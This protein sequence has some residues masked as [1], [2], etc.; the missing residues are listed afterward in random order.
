MDSIE[1]EGLTFQ[2]GVFG[3]EIEA[4]RMGSGEKVAL[5][6]HNGSGKTT[7]LEC[8]VGLQKPTGRLEVLGR[9]PRYES[10]ALYPE[11]SY[12]MQNPDD[13]LFCNRVREDILFGPRNFDLLES[14]EEILRRVNAQIRVEPLL[15]RCT[16]TLSYGEKK[17]ATLAVALATNPRLLLL[18][19][20]F[21]MLDN[22]QKHGLVRTLARLPQSMVI[23]SHDFSLV[24]RLCHRAVV[25]RAG[26]AIHCG[27]VAVLGDE[28]FLA[29]ADLL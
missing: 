5:T 19:E 4:F 16:H 14:D 28:A 6:G 18:D 3:L 23:A 10:R 12:C 11:V 17:C 9:D 29:E 21:G 24:N 1:I 7:L 15:E 2:R 22:K 13:Q 26:R 25:L 20:P 8:L 27:D